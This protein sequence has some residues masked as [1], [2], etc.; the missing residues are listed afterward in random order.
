MLGTIF[1]LILDPVF[2]TVGIFFFRIIT[3]GKFPTTEVKENHKIL[4]ESIG[5]L[6]SVGVLILI[7]YLFF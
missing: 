5:L 3:L 1:D 2:T 4:F 7:F 6:F